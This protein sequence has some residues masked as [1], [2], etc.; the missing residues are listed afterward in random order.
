MKLG[1]S[2]LV[3]W[4]S[5]VSKTPIADATLLESQ[6]FSFCVVDLPFSCSLY[7]KVYTEEDEDFVFS[8]TR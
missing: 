7:F 4:T 1:V 8:P 2:G 5:Q 3:D 6:G